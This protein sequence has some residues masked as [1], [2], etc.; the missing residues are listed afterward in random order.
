MRLK[1]LALLLLAGSSAPVMA[2]DSIETPQAWR[3]MVDHPVDNLAD[4]RIATLR[5]AL[6]QIP[7]MVL[8][9]PTE[10]QVFFFDV[11]AWRALA[12]GEPG[13]GALNRLALA[14][15]IEAVQ[16]FGYRGLEDW[17]NKAGVPLDEISYF[18]GFGQPPFMISYWGLRDNAAAGALIDT[19]ASRDFTE[20]NGP[21][22]GTL[23]NG[24]PNAIDIQNRDPANPWRGALGKSYFVVQD[25]NAVIQAPAPEAMAL[26]ATNFEASAAD[27]PVMT[28]ALD[29][30]LA[31]VGVDEGRIVQAMVISPAFGLGGFDPASAL[32]SNPGDID[33]TRAALEEAFE[34]SAQGIPPYFGGI[35][36]DVQFGDR[37]ALVVSLAYPDCASADD[38]VAALQARW[39]AGMDSGIEAETS[40]QSVAN[41][42]EL[43]AAVVHFVGEPNEDGNNLVLGE[44]MSRF[45]RRDFNLLQIGATP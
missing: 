24:E 39:A 33:A 8:T 10:M 27:S 23:G 38:A 40:G 21:V 19:L 13:V 14:Q 44:T 32:F 25:E 31:A 22:P 26:L 28:S 1:T 41:S 5:Q 7:E 3:V 34:E 2:Q 16:V 18:A 12:D 43:C 45:M 20:A 17:D 29:G 6:S 37:P 35:V 4:G 11:Q 30:M 36:A 42:G 9:N 15:S